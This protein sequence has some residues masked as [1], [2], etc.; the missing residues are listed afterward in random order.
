MDIKEQIEKIVDRMKDFEGRCVV[1]T[2]F[3]CGTD[4]DGV[5]VD[6]TTPEY[7]NPWLEA[8][9]HIAPREVMI[10]TID[11]ETPVQGLQKASPATLDRIVEQLKERGIK[12]SASY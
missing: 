8:V 10:Y 3:M 6:N 12:A 9:T 5:S 2:L 4:D 11:R 1:Q 7:V